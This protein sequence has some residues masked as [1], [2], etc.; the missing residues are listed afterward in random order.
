M[1]CR[2]RV[3]CLYSNISG[4]GKKQNWSAIDCAIY[5]QENQRTFQ[6]LFFRISEY[7]LR[8]THLNITNMDWVLLSSS[9][10]QW[11]FQENFDLW[12]SSSFQRRFYASPFGHPNGWVHGVT[13]KIRV[14][15]QVVTTT[16]GRTNMR[17]LQFTGFNV[18]WSCEDMWLLLASI[19]YTLQRYKCL[20]VLAVFFCQ[21]VSLMYHLLSIFDSHISPPFWLGPKGCHAQCHLKMKGFISRWVCM[22]YSKCSNH[23]VGPLLWTTIYWIYL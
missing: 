5:R 4:I 18:C 17:L 20:E 11:V 9:P 13:W 12:F 2:N 21:I 7:H 23:R 19:T 3:F 22:V 16:E 10:F 15:T 1:A 6:H 14:W 8:Y